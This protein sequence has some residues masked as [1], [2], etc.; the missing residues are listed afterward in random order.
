MTVQ[1]ILELQRK[2]KSKLAEGGSAPGQT[3]VGAQSDLTK[4][5][6][7]GPDT[8]GA[9]VP[10][11]GTPVGAVTGTNPTTPGAGPE[12]MHVIID[13]ADDMGGGGGGGLTG[14]VNKFAGKMATKGLDFLSKPFQQ[15]FKK[16]APPSAPIAGQQIVPAGQEGGTVPRKRLI[17]K[18]QN[19][20]K[21]KNPF[22]MNMGIVSGAGNL[23]ATSYGGMGKQVTRMPGSETPDASWGQTE[24]N[25]GKKQGMFSGVSK[26]DA[27]GLG[28]AALTG[29]G[30]LITSMKPVGPMNK[31]GIETQ[32]KKGNNMAVAG[33]AVS[34]AAKGF[35][36]GMATGN[37]F[38]A[39]AGGVAG[40]A[41]G[42]FKGKKQVKDQAKQIKSDT[43]MAYEGF[44][45]KANQNQFASLVGKNGVKL[46]VMSKLNNSK[47]DKISMKGR[48]FK[49]GGKLNSVG[50][51]NI[52]PSGTLHRENN[53]LGQKDKGLPIIDDN[54]KK[55]FEIEREEL[56]LRLKTTKAVEEHVEGYKKSHNDT[57]LIKLG[58]LLSEEI[59]KNTHDF[60]GKYGLEVK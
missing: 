55:I 22:S 6:L 40:L 43:Q 50:E 12:P 28:A 14:M 23:G 49:S 56:I 3:S 11:Q 42:I 36:A 57:H 24:S 45:Q 54:G 51:V 60:S 32:T 38:I 30:S 21:A 17:P 20:L 15:M 41:S 31:F 8:S 27:M 35:S 18:G 26:Q 47:K 48:K 39:I 46:A 44:E 25:T 29:A 1:E 59:T 37:P 9:A 34:G 7:R 10:V 53:N 16:K 52:I 58:K 33:S 2:H 5:T 13:N 4:K 19:D